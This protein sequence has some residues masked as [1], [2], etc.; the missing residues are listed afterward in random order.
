VDSHEPVFVAAAN[1]ENAFRQQKGFFFQLSDKDKQKAKSPWGPAN[2]QALNRYS[3]VLNNPVRYVNPIGHLGISTDNC[4]G[5]S[6]TKIH[7]THDE[8]IALWNFSQKMFGMR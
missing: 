2:P 8:A 3:Y 7:L 6:C 5:A 1:G 4:L